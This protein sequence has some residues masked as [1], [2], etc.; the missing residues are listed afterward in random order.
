MISPTMETELTKNHTTTS[1]KL[2]YLVLPFFVLLVGW[3]GW[4]IKSTYFPEKPIHY[5]AGFVVIKNNKQVDFTNIK[6]MHTKPCG[7][8]T[9]THE[10]PEEEQ[11][12][13]AHLHDYVGD[14]V[15][16]H[17]HDAMWGDLF[18]NLKYSIKYADVTAYI[19]GQKISDMQ[20]YPIKAYDS[21][22]I[23]IGKNDVKAG[24]SKAIKKSHVQEVEK[25]SDN[26]GV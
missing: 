12:E 15:H 23:F 21:L 10:D 3:F 9:H 1:R 14:V 22:V 2:L 26:C 19:N 4:M 24:F 16:V 20:H 8:N 6:Y 18:K 25:K 13:K 7:N 17:R 5:H 11:I